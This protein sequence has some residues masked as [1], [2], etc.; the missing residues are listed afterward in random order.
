MGGKSGGVTR[1]TKRGVTVQFDRCE[2][3][4]VDGGEG[5]GAGDAGRWGT[6][7]C[8][9]WLF[10]MPLHIPLFL[11][12]DR[13]VGL[14]DHIVGYF[15]FR[16]ILE[17]QS[18]LVIISA[19]PFIHS[20]IGPLQVL[21]FG[22]KIALAG[23][24]PSGA[25][26]LGG[27]LLV[28]RV[29]WVLQ[30]LGHR[31]VSGQTAG[32]AVAVPEHVFLGAVVSLEGALAAAQE[33]EEQY[34]RHAQQGYSPHSAPDGGAGIVRLLL[35]LTGLIW[36]VVRDFCDVD[37]H[38]AGTSPD[39]IGGVAN[40][41]SCQVVGHRA[42]EEQGV[43]LDLHIAGQGAIQEF[44]LVD[45]DRGVSISTAGQL[46]ILTV[47]VPVSIKPLD[48]HH[49]LILYIEHHAVRDLLVSVRYDARELLSVGLAARRHQI[50][51]SYRHRTVLVAGLLESGFAFQPGVP[52]DH[53][54]GL[55]IGRYA[56]GNSH[57][58]LLGPGHDRWSRQGHARH[59]P[60]KYSEVDHVLP[61]ACR[62]RGVLADV[63]SLVRQLQV[64]EHDGGV[65]QRGR[66]MTN[67]RLLEAD[68]LLEGRQHGHAQCRVGDGHVLLGAV[69]ELL[70]GDLRDLYRRVAVDEN[71]AQLHLRTHEAG[72]TGVHLY[73][74]SIASLNMHRQ[75][76]HPC[77][78][79]QRH[80]TSTIRI[81][82]D[83]LRVD[84]R[85]SLETTKTTHATSAKKIPLRTQTSRA[86]SLRLSQN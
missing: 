9:V 63:G 67:R 2:G 54:R 40:V 23:L 7:G 27:L 14:R 77:P 16:V 17:G 83:N 22:V 18:P 75:Q 51:A 19:L 73:H 42:L 85:G 25:A 48:R 50:V 20:E 24:E 74:L 21:C 26:N 84:G 6:K 65:L 79:T 8:L 81:S 30:V 5:C 4:V 62:K 82:S 35:D 53:A 61:I 1:L 56:S 43:V 33:Y 69:E 12:N 10:C 68:P 76:E 52:F 47:Q 11:R 37:I 64:G 38:D 41:R 58:A 13:A 31:R 60:S 34:G 66:A 39:A 55:P 72:L 29:V 59:G 44:P 46:N 32:L 86:L 36:L 71:A 3:G 45:R 15:R 80:G 57:L 49:G 78:H 28:V 70:P